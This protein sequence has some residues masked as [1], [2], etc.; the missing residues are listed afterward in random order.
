MKT[1]KDCRNY[2]EKVSNML[3]EKETDIGNGEKIINVTG[4][5]ETER[6][7]VVTETIFLETQK[8]MLEWFLEEVEE[9]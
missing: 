2:L 7:G 9:D 4:L 3:S 5:S 6:E 1:E 8:Y